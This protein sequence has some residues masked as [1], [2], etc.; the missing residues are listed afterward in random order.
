MTRSRTAL[1]LALSIA[2]AGCAGSMGGGSSAAPAVPSGPETEESHADRPNRVVTITATRLVPQE[3]HMGTGD[4]LAF[5]NLSNTTMQLTF[6]EPKYMG[7]H[8]TCT[9]VKRVSPTE[10]VARGAVFQLQGDEV[11]ATLLPGTFV[12]VCSLQPGVYVYT[13]QRSFEGALTDDATLG[14]KGTIVVE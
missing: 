3:L 13:A 9:Q 2:A 14:M 12:G 1:L 8:T 5:H 10:A 7:R 11:T 6:I 4:V